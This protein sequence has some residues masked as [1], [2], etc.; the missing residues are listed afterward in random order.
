[1]AEKP[2][3]K[4]EFNFFCASKEGEL[5]G[6]VRDECGLDEDAELVKQAERRGSAVAVLMDIQD[7]G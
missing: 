7:G 6:R 3:I 1:M 4:D 2:G 5:S